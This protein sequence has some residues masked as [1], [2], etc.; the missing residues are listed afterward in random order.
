MGQFCHFA[1]PK[2]YVQLKIYTIK[3]REANGAGGREKESSK[4]LR[5]CLVG[6]VEK[7]NDKK[8]FNFS[9]FCLWKNREI[10]KMSLYK[11]YSLHLLKND[12]QLKQKS[13]K[14]QIKIQSPKFIKN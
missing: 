8:D 3:Q 9:S 10:K 2:W 4:N 12:T 13:D 5:I 7:W 11:F 1:E 14:Q 6:G